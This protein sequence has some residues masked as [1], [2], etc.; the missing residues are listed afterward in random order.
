M[1]VYNLDTILFREQRKNKNKK[2][3]DWVGVFLKVL[4]VNKWMSYWLNDWLKKINKTKKKKNV[5]KWINAKDGWI[6]GWC[7]CLGTFMNE[8]FCEY[9]LLNVNIWKGGAIM[10]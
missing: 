2:Q 3:V 7:G 6:D 5:V 4:Q 10:S 9:F 1:P 8:C